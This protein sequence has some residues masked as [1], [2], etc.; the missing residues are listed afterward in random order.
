MAFFKK[1]KTLKKLKENQHFCSWTAS[2]SHLGPLEKHLGPSWGHLE[3]LLGPKA[4]ADGRYRW[5]L[6]ITGT[7]GS[8]QLDARAE[9][10]GLDAG[11]VEVERRRQ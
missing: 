2:W 3:A 11:D 5:Q 8:W 7:A 4:Q 10:Q 1:R 6:N 9:S